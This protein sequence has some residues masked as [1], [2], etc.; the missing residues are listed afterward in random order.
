MEGRERGIAFELGVAE[1]E[2]PERGRVVG[3]R[4]GEGAA[5]EEGVAVEECGA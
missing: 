1:D 4:G 3:G 5:E 2:E